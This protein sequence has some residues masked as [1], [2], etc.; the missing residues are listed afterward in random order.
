MYRGWTDEVLGSM[1]VL[2]LDEAGVLKQRH[3]SG[4]HHRL[5]SQAPLLWHVVS[6]CEP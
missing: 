1:F 5:S 6:G 3:I 2:R 4:A